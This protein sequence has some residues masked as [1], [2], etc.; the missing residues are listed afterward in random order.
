[1][2]KNIFAF[3]T[4]LFALLMVSSA[5]TTSKTTKRGFDSK[6]LALIKALEKT[7]GGWKAL[8]K[9]KDVEYLYTYNDLNKKAKDISI[10]RYIFDGEHSWADY[11]TDHAVNVMPGVASIF[12]T[13]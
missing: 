8:S 4:V 6:S 1:M 3:S 13:R 7:N 2:R 10:E 5:F 9:L 11:K 12:A